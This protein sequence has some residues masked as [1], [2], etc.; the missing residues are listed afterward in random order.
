[1]LSKAQNKLILELLS[2]RVI[3][4][5]QGYKE[6]RFCYE[7]AK[8]TELPHCYHRPRTVNKQTVWALMSDGLIEKK[9][10]WPDHANPK[11][12][13]VLSEKGLKLDVRE[14]LKSRIIWKALNHLEHQ[15]NIV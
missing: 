8:V 11:E 12:I 6:G 3:C 5:R 10:V 13:Y 1:M 4:E 14:L 7:T 9:T 2:G 15:R